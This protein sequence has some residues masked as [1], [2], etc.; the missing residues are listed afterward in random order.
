MSESPKTQAFQRRSARLPA[1]PCAVLAS[2]ALHAGLLTLTAGSGFEPQARILPVLSLSL[3]APDLDPVAAMQAQQ[4][5]ALAA[6]AAAAP[7]QAP[8]TQ[9][10]RPASALPQPRQEA[11]AA[12]REDAT[13]VAPTVASAPPAAPARAAM[14]S[15]ERPTASSGGSGAPVWDIAAWVERFKTYPRAARR[16]RLEGTAEIWLLLD[17]QGQL[18]DHRLLASSGHRLLDEAALA[19]VRRAAP[20]PAPTAAAFTRLEVILPVSYRLDRG[21]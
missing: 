10:T 12:P 20:Y 2:L 15:P 3:R 11:A 13:P 19:L 16:A 14:P 8:P 7:E 18:H 5:T 21:S 1:L 9:A 4:A 6:P 17:D